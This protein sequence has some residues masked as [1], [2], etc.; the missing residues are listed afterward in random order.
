MCRIE[1]LELLVRD[2][3][4][5]DP[6]GAVDVDGGWP[7]LVRKAVAVDQRKRFASCVPMKAAMMTMKKANM[8]A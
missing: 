6:E 7:A 2:L 4:P 8:M 5:A 3:A 1:A